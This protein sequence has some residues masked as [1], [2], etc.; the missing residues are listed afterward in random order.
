LTSSGFAGPLNGTV[1]ATTANTGSF[2]TLTT[3]S[4]IT[5]N[6][7]TANGVTY[8][9]GSKVVT[10]GSALQFDGSSTLT[11]GTN[12]VVRNSSG[13]NIFRAD[14][15]LYLDAK[16]G[17]VSGDILFR[18]AS[19]E[20]MRL[21]STGLGIGTSSPAV[22]LDVY[23]V[24]RAST[25][26]S[27]YTSITSPALGGVSG[28]VISA[29]NNLELTADSLSSAST[30]LIFKTSASGTTSEKMRI[31]SSGNLGLGVTPSAWQ[32][33]LG[34]R[35]I[36]FTG[37]AVYGY[38]D[39]NLILSQ[40]AYYDG[41]WKYYASSIAAG[42]YSI[43]SGAHAWNTAASGTAG[44]AITF[45]TAMLL[46][47]SGNLGIGTSSPVSN[48]RLTSSLSYDGTGG[49]LVENTST[50]VSAS[51]A[52]RY[53][54]S[55]STVAYTLLGGTNRASYG[56]LGA[57][58]MSMYTDNTAGISL[59][60]DAA[61]PITF[62]TNAT[63]RMRI[64]S[65]GNVGIGTSSP[66]GRMEVA[67]TGV[68][69]LRLSSTQTSPNNILMT[70]GS[71]YN[72][73]V[74]GVNTGNNTSTGDIFHLGYTASAGAAPVSILQWSNAAKCIGLN[75]T[76]ATSGTGITF[77]ATQNASSDANTLDDYEEGTW[78]PVLVDNSANQ[79]TMTVQQGFYTK[80]GNIVYAWCQVA[81]SSKASM[82]NILYKITGL[83]FSSKGN[84]GGY[85]YG[86][87]SQ[88]TTSTSNVIACLDGGGSAFLF[89]PSNSYTTDG[90]AN[91]AAS[92]RVI[93]T[94]TYPV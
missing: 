71:S 91:L 51:S 67:A 54:N 31:D 33:T 79:A 80:V 43:G 12:T 4:T 59:V 10:S 40:N 50:G 88:V 19:T 64:D 77:P 89:F 13:F 9:N 63:E 48:F 57:N 5:D 81:Y 14:T 52:T 83:P 72:Y 44:A 34:S 68:P 24:V 76:P 70:G 28:K 11:M 42:Y 23:G 61:G 2:T 56:G 27:L 22:K 45:T 29:D 36:Q 53:K 37:S 75:T 8:L 35:A 65:S 94:M 73:G 7:G 74:I 32:S 49:L 86:G 16:Q 58:I 3:S 21:T 41:A 46:D 26:A 6:G 82:S 17:G 85:Y 25:G 69:V 15:D 1:G 60:V 38:R 62:N 84:N 20:Q 92:G 93:V 39:T 66:T 30:N 78:T 55:G 90:I 87:V 47:A 18:Q